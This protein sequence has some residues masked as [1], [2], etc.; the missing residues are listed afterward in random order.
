M[1]D[2]PREVWMYLDN[3]GTW[4]Y[5]PKFVINSVRYIR[6][7][8]A[9]PSRDSAQVPRI[10]ALE[11]VAEAAYSAREV[12]SQFCKCQICERLNEAL[13]ALDA[14]PAQAEDWREIFCRC[15][16]GEYSHHGYPTNKPCSL[17]DCSA[18][19]PILINK[20]DAVIEECAKVCEAR[21]TV[22]SEFYAAD[23]RALKR[24]QSGGTCE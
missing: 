6:A 22:Y 15:G 14:A 9:P 23:V 16:H 8:L 18:Y 13:N 11:Q 1:A 4:R 21:G 24:S 17:C 2:A 10:A 12:H 3:R 5:M 19:S 20:R 7:D